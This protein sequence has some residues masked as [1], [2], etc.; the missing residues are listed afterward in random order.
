MPDAHRIGVAS[1]DAGPTHAEGGTHDTTTDA[2]KPKAEH[3]FNQHEHAAATPSASPS[4][5]AT[6]EE[7]H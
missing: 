2:H 5:S 7:Q 3:D 1:L 6:P 4:S